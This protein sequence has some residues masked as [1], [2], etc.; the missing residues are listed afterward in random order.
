M[1]A[2]LNELSDLIYASKPFVLNQPCVNSG[3]KMYH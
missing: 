2:G 1:D 3:V